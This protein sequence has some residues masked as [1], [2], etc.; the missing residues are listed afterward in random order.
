MKH[1]KKKIDYDALL[2]FTFAVVFKIQWLLLNT[3]KSM[4]L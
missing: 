4:Y 3:K 2:Y 1:N